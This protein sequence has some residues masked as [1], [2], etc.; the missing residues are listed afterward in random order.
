MTSTCAERPA[1]ASAFSTASYIEAGKP[2][3]RFNNY[4]AEERMWLCPEGGPFSLW[5]KPGA[6]QVMKN[7]YTPP[8]LNEGA[9][10]VVS[11]QD[12]A[13]VRM[14]AHMKFQNASGT[15]FNIDVIREVRLLG[16][17]DFR[18]LF[19]A[20]AATTVAQAAPKWWPTK[21]STR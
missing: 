17:E 20:T 10:K 18:Q 14:T 5:F 16:A 7:W 4:G 9:W 13:E 19:G 1:R 21:P 8:A 2:D 3:P 12:A 15:D 11:R 6:K